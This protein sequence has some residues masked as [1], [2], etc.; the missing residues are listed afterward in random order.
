MFLNLGELAGG[1]YSFFAEPRADLL[2]AIGNG[3]VEIQHPPIAPRD[4]RTRRPDEQT[5]DAA[6]LA[7]SRA[8]LTQPK[9]L[10]AL[11]LLCEA[12]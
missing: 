7:A 8:G 10:A 5:G 3:P 12:T 1:P 11:E 9:M 4:P 6:L 2:P